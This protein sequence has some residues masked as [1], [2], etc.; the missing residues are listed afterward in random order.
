MDDELKSVFL[1]CML[2][3]SWDT[4]YTAIS[5]SAPKDKLVCT[6]I[7]EALLNEEIRRQSMVTSQVGEAY[8]V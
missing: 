1:L 2:P 6:D 5:N 7:C 8:N 4:F 3:A